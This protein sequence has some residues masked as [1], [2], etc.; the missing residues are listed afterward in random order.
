MLKFFFAGKKVTG[1]S[2][3]ALVEAVD[4]I[5]DEKDASGSEGA[6]HVAVHAGT[7]DVKD[8]IE[9]TLDSNPELT[10]RSKISSKGSTK[11]LHDVLAQDATVSK[12]HANWA[13]LVRFVRVFVERH[14]I[15]GGKMDS[16]CGGNLIV[17]DELTNVTEG[18]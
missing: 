16:H 4:E 5:N 9:T 1:G 11:S 8:E 13:E 7:D 18:F 12:T 14:E 6:I 2:S 15:V 17:D 10:K 3:G